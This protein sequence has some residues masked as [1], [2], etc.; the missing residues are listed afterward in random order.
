MPDLV[1]SIR[2]LAAVVTLAALA[3]PLLAQ[4]A[5]SNNYKNDTLVKTYDWHFGLYNGDKCNIVSITGG[6]ITA[7]GTQDPWTGTTGGSSGDLVA[8][9]TQAGIDIGQ[10]LGARIEYTGDT[11]KYYW[12]WTDINHNLTGQIHQVPSPSAFSLL[13]LSGVLIPRRCR[14]RHALH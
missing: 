1:Q 4:T 14:E 6:R 11:P 9:A 8:S 5:F 2:T 3:T 10:F 12:W 7:G 13:A